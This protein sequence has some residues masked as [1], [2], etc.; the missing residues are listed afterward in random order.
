MFRSAFAAPLALAVAACVPASNAP[1]ASASKAEKH[2][3][4]RLYDASLDAS[5]AVDAALER[6]AG[7]NVNALVVMGANWCHDS[8]AFAGWSET[9]RFAAMLAQRFELVFI[10]VGM[11]QTGDGHNLHIAKR[12]GIEEL[13]GTPTVLVIAPD[14][15]VL[16]GD[17]A[18]TWRDT[19]SRS[20]DAVF[21]ELAAFPLPA[22]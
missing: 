9:P 17:T 21:E 4:A 10:N 6:A 22:R 7:R 19:A 20:E 12:F 14:G 11:P 18:K 2:P 15:N 1:V 8:R 13:E 3:E 5:M 16:N